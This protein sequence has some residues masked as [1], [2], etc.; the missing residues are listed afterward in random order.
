[1]KSLCLRRSRKRRMMVVVEEV[2]SHHN[3][4]SELEGINT[5]RKYSGTKVHEFNL[6]LEAVRHLKCL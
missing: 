4:L 5:A 6:F 2:N 1:L 3:I